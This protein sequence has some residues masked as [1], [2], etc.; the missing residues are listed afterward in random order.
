L[1]AIHVVLEPG[2]AVPG[3][4]EDHSRLQVPHRGQ[5]GARKGEKLVRI[6]L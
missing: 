2:E 1:R 3:W 4:G 6:A 5:G